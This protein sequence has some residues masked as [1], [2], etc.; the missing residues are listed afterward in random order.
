MASTPP[1]AAASGKLPA[2]LEGAGS[3][4]EEIARLTL[5]APVLARPVESEGRFIALALV[6]EEIPAA[7]EWEG[8]REGFL[9]KAHERKKE[10]I[11]A[12]FVAEKRKA[13]KVVVKKEALQ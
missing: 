13:A 6:S 4:R 1:F 12:S 3:A 5:V 2:P 11:F 9:K 7:A 8:E 10:E